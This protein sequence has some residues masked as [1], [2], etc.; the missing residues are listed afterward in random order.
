MKPYACK[1]ITDIAVTFNPLQYAVKSLP[2]K[3]S[4][5]HVLYDADID[6]EVDDVRFLKGEK[7]VLFYSGNQWLDLKSQ[8]NLAKFVDNGGTLICFKDYPRQDD[9]FNELNLLRFADPNGVLF[10]FKRSFEVIL[11]NGMSA[12]AVSRLEFFHKVPGKKIEA[13]TADGKKYIVGYEK[14]F[15]QGRIIYFGIDPNKEI[16]FALSNYLGIN[17]YAYSKTKDVKTALFQR[18]ANFYLVA[19][20]NGNENKGANI[21]F[22]HPAFSRCK[23]TVN[24]IEKVKNKS[25]PVLKVPSIGIELLRKDGKVFEVKI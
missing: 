12:M 14:T 21:V 5:L 18:G 8:E 4:I 24:N 25:K 11:P 19:V 6:Y 13:K 3:D 7:K 22:T 17:L 2:N 15:G 23:Y 16:M 10:E 1:K 9:F 20:N